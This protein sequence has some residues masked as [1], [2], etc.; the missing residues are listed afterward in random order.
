MKT[1]TRPVRSFVRPRSHKIFEMQEHIGG[2]GVHA[3][4]AGLLQTAPDPHTNPL[5]TKT[6]NSGN[7]TEH[8]GV[9]LSQRD[10]CQSVIFRFG[11]GRATL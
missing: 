1:S 10:L 8:G 7:F 5:I 9:Y 11:T 4:C 6:F 3:K 2:P